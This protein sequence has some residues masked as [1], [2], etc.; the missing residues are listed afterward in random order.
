VVTEARDFDPLERPRSLRTFGSSG[1][2][3]MEIA[4]AYDPTGRVA[5]LATLVN[6]SPVGHWRGYAYDTTGR[7]SDLPEAEN[8]PP[9]SSDGRPV[10]N[11]LSLG[12][13]LGAVRWKYARDGVIGSTN[14][15]SAPTVPAVRWSA[16]LPRGPGYQLRQLSVNGAPPTGVA[17]DVY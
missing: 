2:A 5:S 3:L 8:V 12:D 16:S 11:V 14:E 6:G 9:P 7:L 10:T 17:Q 15:I 4:A 13:T 1:S